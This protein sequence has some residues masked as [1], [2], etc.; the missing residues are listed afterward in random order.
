M[1]SSPEARF[2]SKAKSVINDAIASQADVTKQLKKQTGK[3][4]GK[5]APQNYAQ[6]SRE[7]AKASG[8]TFPEFVDVAENRFFNTASQLTQ[9][10]RQ[11]LR[12][13]QP[14]LLSS[15]STQQLTDY[16]SAIGEDFASGIKEVGEQGRDRLFALPEQARV[17]FEA[18]SGN[19]AF[20]N[21]YN[22]QYMQLA[23]NPPTIQNDAMNMYR[24]LFTY[25][26]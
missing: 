18:T 24:S 25:N 5:N 22:E 23:K 9:Q 10:G 21:I 12:N 4:I 15:S 14:N 19:P 6:V 2:K 16:L 11:D 17:A 7:I 1:G 26:V 20:D 3:Y 13:F 8:R